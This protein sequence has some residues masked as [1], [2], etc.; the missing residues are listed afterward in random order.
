MQK[1]IFFQLLLSFSKET[2]KKYSQPGKGKNYI[3]FH[4]YTIEIKNH[5]ISQHK[6]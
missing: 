4:M 5:N 3:A 1:K 6:K 2:F